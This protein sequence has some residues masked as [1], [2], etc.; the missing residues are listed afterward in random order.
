MTINQKLRKHKLKH[1]H[2]IAGVSIR[3]QLN[4]IKLFFIQIKCMLIK[5]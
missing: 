1:V 5:I 4:H 3:S 2:K